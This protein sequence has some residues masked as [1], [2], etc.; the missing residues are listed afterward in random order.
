MHGQRTWAFPGIPYIIDAPVFNDLGDVLTIDPGNTLQFTANGWLNIR[1][2]LE[3]LGTPSEPITLTARSQ[4]PGGWRGLIIDGGAHQAV[5]HLD[6]VTVEYAGNDINGANIEVVNGRLIVHHSII[7]HSSKDGVRFDSNWGGSILESQIISN[8]LYGVRNLTPARAVLA[9]NNWWGDAGGPQSDVVG[10]SSGL[11]AKVSAG[12]LF[13]PVL[14]STLTTCVNP[15]Q[16]GA[17]PDIDTPA[18]VCARQWGHKRSTLTLHCGMAT[19]R[20]CP[21]APWN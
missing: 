21:D 16:R 15:A 7:R 20:P 17:E 18:L 8:A 13:S 9:T 14:T 10:C 3:A 5:A 6:Y 1:G 2:R 11:G 19:A 12:V 4:T